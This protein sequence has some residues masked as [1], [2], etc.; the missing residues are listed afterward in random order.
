[1][2]HLWPSGERPRGWCVYWWWGIEE[3]HHRW[4]Y[5]LS[6]DSAMAP[7]HRFPQSHFFSSPT[8]VGRARF[9]LAFSHRGINRMS[10]C[11]PALQHLSHLTGCEQPDALVT[12]RTRSSYSIELSEVKAHLSP[13]LV[14]WWSSGIITFWLWSLK[15]KHLVQS[16]GIQIRLRW[17]NLHGKW[18]DYLG[19]QIF[20]FYL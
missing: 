13:R 8:R 16:S 15:L 14:A 18:F 5:L 19:A 17:W 7:L 1:M 3:F 11:M 2:L 6:S 10:M 12:Q 20:Y 4:W 9:Q